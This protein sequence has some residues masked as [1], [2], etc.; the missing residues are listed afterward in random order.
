MDGRS[1]RTFNVIDDYNR[2]GLG[3]D[4]GLSLPSTRVIRSL[5]LFKTIEHA[6][7]LATQW[8]WT[9]N[10]GKRSK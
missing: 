9:Y 10:N 1:I 7:L 3:I 4:V 6:Q 5:H 8:L 2:E